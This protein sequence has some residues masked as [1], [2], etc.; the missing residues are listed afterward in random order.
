MVYVLRANVRSVRGTQN[1]VAER[2]TRP[3]LWID[4]GVAEHVE[5]DGSGQRVKL[6][7]SGAA[8][9]SQR[10]NPVQH[11]R[12]PGRVNDFETTWFSNLL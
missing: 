1:E 8:F 5:K 11:F 6:R 4:R 12:D 7:E 2:D 3:S 10:I 9:G